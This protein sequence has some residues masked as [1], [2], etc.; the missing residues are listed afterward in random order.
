MINSS[1]GPRELTVVSS[2]HEIKAAAKHRGCKVSTAGEFI[3]DSASQLARARSTKNLEPEQKQKGLTRSE[4]DDWLSE[5][6]IDPNEEDDPYERM[7]G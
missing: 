5:F 6:E 3:K 4:T 1:S 2:D 7:R